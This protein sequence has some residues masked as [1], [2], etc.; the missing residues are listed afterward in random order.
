MFAE[1]TEMPTAS[2]SGSSTSST[3]MPPPPREPRRCRPLELELCSSSKILRY[4]TT[5]YPNKLGHLSIQDVKADVIA[6]RYK[7]YYLLIYYIIPI[8]G[9]FGLLV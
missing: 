3:T 6:F 1:S 2:G 4:N 5:S 9:L 8:R 7:K